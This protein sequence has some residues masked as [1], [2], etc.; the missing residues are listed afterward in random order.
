MELRDVTKNAEVKELNEIKL[1]NNLTGFERSR[2]YKQLHIKSTNAEEG[3]RKARNELM[4]SIW[5]F[6]GASSTAGRS[7]NILTVVPEL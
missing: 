6:R 2:A 3:F 4:E 1:N 7:L 5:A